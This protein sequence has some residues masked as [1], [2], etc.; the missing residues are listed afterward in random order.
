MSILYF[1]TIGVMLDFGVDVNTVN[2]RLSFV[3]TE[4]LAM[5]L[6]LAMQNLLGGHR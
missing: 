1:V 3:Y 5:V 2:Q 6:A 4:L